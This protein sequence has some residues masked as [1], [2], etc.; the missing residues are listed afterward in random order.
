MR[1]RSLASVL[2]IALLPACAASRARQIETWVDTGQSLLDVN[3]PKEAELS[4]ERALELDEDSLD[5]RVGL[6]RSWM[7]QGRNND[8]LDAI[9]ELKRDGLEGPPLDYLYGMAFARR[10]QTKVAQGDL[11]GTVQMNFQDAVGLLEAAVQ[12][13]PERYE[14][15]W[16]ALAE[17]A[18]MSL[19]LPRAREA[20][21]R[22]V[23]SFPERGDDRALLGRIAFSQF[24]AAYDDAGGSI[25]ATAGERLD[26]ALSA[27]RGA[28]TTYGPAKTDEQGYVLSDVEVQIGN[29]L[30]WKEDASAAADA[31]TNAIA[32]A[33]DAV[34]YAQTLQ[35]FDASTF[36]DVLAG[37]LARFEAEHVGADPETGEPAPLPERANALAWWLAYAEYAAGNHEA[38]EAGFQR[39]LA[40]DDSFV[41]SWFYLAQTRYAREDWPGT[42]DALRSG[43]TANPEAV[44]AEMQTN[45]ELNLAKVSYVVGWCANAE[46]LEDAALLSRINAESAVQVPTYWSDLGLF[47][48]D[49][50]DELGETAEAQALHEEAFEAYQRALALAPQDPQILND[51]AVMLT[52]YL[53]R[54]YG[55]ALEMFDQAQ[56]LARETLETG[57]VSAEM[58]P[59]LEKAL[60]DATNNGRRL[61][62]AL[63]RAAEKAAAE[64][65]GTGE[66]GAAED[67]ASE[68]QS[69]SQSDAQS[70]AGSD[71][72]GEASDGSER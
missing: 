11:D 30:L 35:L 56:F 23:A 44:V 40:L 9:D 33:P 29:A 71:A 39:A 42:I 49:R 17:S 14:D 5:A 65:E 47:L 48:R 24:R 8:S 6:L 19:D 36:R 38:A 61:R 54:E 15:A 41:N 50:G 60:D 26:D 16:P 13:D 59:I 43:W 21:E 4:F 20:A 67:S 72:A 1:L 31:Y 57:E 68:A 69:D 2:L 58:Q 10:A 3:R 22:A 46:R 66:A 18:W 55:R 64:A 32:L 25:D 53:H 7:D 45:L 37:G 62:E 12:A 70:D 63:E 51:T 28:L 52:Y 34:D 27:F